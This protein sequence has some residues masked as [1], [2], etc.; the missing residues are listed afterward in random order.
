MNGDVTIDEAEMVV[1][2]VSK[3]RKSLARSMKDVDSA[4]GKFDDVL[5]IVVFVIGIFILISFLNTDFATTL[6]TAGTALIS[7]SFIFALTCQEILASILFLFY[8]HPFDVGDRVDVSGAHYVVK[9]LSLLFTV[10]KRTDGTIVQVNNAILNGLFIEN[11]RRSATMSEKVQLQVDFGTTFFTIQR[12]RAEMQSFVRANSRDYASELEIEIVDANGLDKLLLQIIIK[13][14]SNWQNDAL[15][16]HRRN[17]V[18][19]LTA[20]CTETHLLV[21]VRIGP[22]D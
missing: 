22:G 19:P 10:F 2:E 20:V 14:K 12:L 5:V 16:A 15:K 13:H 1:H 4:I 6:A 11:I 8:K 21:Y 7:L 3:E 9:E 17:K 18:P